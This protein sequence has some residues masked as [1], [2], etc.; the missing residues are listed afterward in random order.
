MIV[1][2]LSVGASDVE[3]L[4]TAPSQARMLEEVWWTMLEVEGLLLGLPR[5][6]LASGGLLST[7][8][9]A[10]GDFI[11]PDPPTTPSATHLATYGLDKGQFFRVDPHPSCLPSHTPD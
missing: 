1:V 9:S 11:P 6:L 7:L 4:K 8:W 10:L 5:D 2:D 3:T